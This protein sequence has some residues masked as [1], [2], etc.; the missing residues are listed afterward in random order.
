MFLCPFLYFQMPRWGRVF[1]Q[2]NV[3][4]PGVQLL[5]AYVHWTSSKTLTIWREQVLLMATAAAA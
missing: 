2:S 5:A 3:A 4:R 1:A